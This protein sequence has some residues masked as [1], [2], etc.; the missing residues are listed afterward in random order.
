[1][2]QVAICLGLRGSEI[3]ALL[4][5]TVVR[6]VVHG[7]VSRVKTEYCEDGLPLDSAFAELLLEWQTRCPI[8][9]GN[10]E[11]SNPETG[12][13]YHASP[14]QQDYIRAAG[15]EAKLP[16]DVGWHSFRHAYRSFLDMGGAPIGVQQKLM[17][18]AQVSTTMNTYG[19]AQMHSKRSA[20]TKVVQMVLPQVGD[21]L[22]EAS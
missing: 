6:K 9:A 5:L 19:N 21:R 1:M 3:L 13:L 12:Q 11:F 20:N 10:W 4:T 15:R 22:K 14:I 18:Y 8:S 2:V 16:K 7:R 17:R